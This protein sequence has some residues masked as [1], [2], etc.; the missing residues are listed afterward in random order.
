MRYI[1]NVFYTIKEHFRQCFLLHLN[2]GQTCH[3]T[4]TNVLFLTD[5]NISGIY[6]VERCDLHNLTTLNVIIVYCDF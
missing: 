5:Y 2:Y 3:S 6:Y 4:L 1:F